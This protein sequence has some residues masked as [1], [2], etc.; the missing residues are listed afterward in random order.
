MSYLEQ[1]L[2]VMRK[3]DAD[4]AERMEGD[5]DCSHIEVI[6]SRQAGVVTARITLQSGEK[7]L[8][9]N[10]EDPIGSA[11]RSAEKQELKAADA[12]ILLGFGL[13]Y[14]SRELAAKLEKMHPL[15]ICEVDPA[16]LKTALI[17]VDL[18]VVLDSDFIK[19]LTGSEI[20][21]QEWIQRL[22]GRFMTA[23]VEAISYE[24]SLR[25]N[26]EAY[27]R[28]KEISQKESRAILLNKN[29]T[30][31]A[32]QK[33]MVN[34]LENFPKVIQS[35]GVKHLQDVFKGRPAIL[36]AA[37]PSLEKNVHLLREVEGRAVIIA[38]DTALR[39]LLPLGIKPDI[40]TTID[41]N[42]KNFQKFE[43]VPI[44]QD[45]SL[46]YHPGGYHESITAFHGPKFTYS[47]APT[48]VHAWLMEYVED[49]GQV[50]AGTTVA[51]LSFFLARYLGCD[52]IVMIGQDLAFPMNKIHAGD[53]SLW[54]INHNEMDVIEDIFGEPVGS[55]PSFKHAI[56][57][58]EKAFQDTKA[59]VIDATEA[60]AKKKGAHV[61]R[62]RD[63]IDEHC[64]VTPIDVKKILREASAQ[65]EPARMDELLR[66]L[67]YVSAELGAIQ[68][69]CGRI[70]RVVRKLDKKIHK[71][72]M[73][74]DD[75][76]KLSCAAEKLT[77]EMEHRGR[78]LALMAEQK[79]SLELYMQ[80]H[81]ISSMDEIEDIDEKIRQQVSRAKIYYPQLSR[82]TEFFKRALDRML[83]RLRRADQLSSDRLATGATAE[84]WYQ[85]AFALRKIEYPRDAIGALRRALV[86]DQNHIQA[87]KV[88]CRLLLEGNRL[89]E[90]LDVLKRLRSLCPSD[91]RVAA[92][93]GKVSAKHELWTQRCDR[94]KSEFL[95]ERPTDTLDDAGWFYYRV[96]DYTRA[97]AKL[98]RALLQTPSAET[99]CRLGQAKAKLGD[100]E[101][102]IEAWES[103][104]RLD[105]TRA[106][107][108]KELGMVTRD[109]GQN[110]QAELFFQEAVRLEPDDAASWEPLARL[111][112]ERAAY[113]EAGLCY[114]QLLR[115]SPDRQE[116]IPQI[117][118]LY[119]RQIAVSV[120][121]Q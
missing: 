112:I 35:A 66:E 106:D 104:L 9:H 1:N 91:R 80:T 55:M 57:H 26:P 21:L 44:D 65:V 87:L 4:L 6:P 15:L 90:A 88:L 59:V 105:P 46:V 79:F 50:P 72:E 85:R 96:K 114:E 16:I 33:M 7:V 108:Y 102:A 116:L 68:N 52:P 118:A 3:H 78:I 84:Q 11:K 10:M 29:T 63:V 19:I 62:L 53:L 41:F 71:G 61:M 70:M 47:K 39:L 81:A 14:L 100:L 2:A 25:T 38:V 69:D 110:E 76:V 36:V 64:Q 94:L 17:H 24:P 58:F 120:N 115:L 12:T 56:Y 93:S 48:R 121:T 86:L 30:V 37:G 74:D 92:L 54:D 45:V 107:I 99:Y 113:T 8:L 5:I 42:K 75:F 27:D 34:L 22:A 119:Q 97:I 101:G 111:C 18:T 32:G 40:V 73:E 98:E 49:K 60:G 31:R 83:G 117:A 67:E 28:L 109:Q 82:T 89:E 77:Q 23:D 51:H 13:G 43:N 20:P 95:R 103:G